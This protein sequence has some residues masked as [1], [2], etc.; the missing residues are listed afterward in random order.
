MQQQMLCDT[1]SGDAK[2]IRKI[3]VWT[4]QPNL[5]GFFAFHDLPSTGLSLANR[6]DQA[7]S[8]VY[9]QVSCHLCP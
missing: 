8:D 3:L 1:I 6:C 2:I 5:A 4:L 9:S 7:Y